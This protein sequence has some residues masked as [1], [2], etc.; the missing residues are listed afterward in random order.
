VCFRFGALLLTCV[1]DSVLEDKQGDVVPV[2]LLVVA[3][4]DDH[5]AEGDVLDGHAAE[6]LAAVD[7]AVGVPLAHA[8][9]MT[10]NS[11]SKMRSFQDF[12]SQ[13]VFVGFGK[14]AMGRRQD[15]P[16][17]D[18]GAGARILHF[19]GEDICDNLPLDVC[20]FF[21]STHS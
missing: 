20:N 17:V 3:G 9:G 8:D 18:D 21:K 4:V 5:V 13:F 16:V 7:V 2:G 15:Y 14:G 1:V 10:G 11:L 6:L 19:T 12:H